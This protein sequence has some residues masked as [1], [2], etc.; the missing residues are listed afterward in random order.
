LY[1]AV[2]EQFARLR[3][4]GVTYRVIPGVTAAFAASAALG[5]EYTLPEVCQTLIITRAAGRTPTPELEDLAFLARHRAAMAIYLSA[6]LADQVAGALAPHYGRDAAAAVVYRASWPDE[7]ILFTTVGDLARDMAEAGVDRQAL[8][9]VGEAV[10][11][12]QKGEK[13]PASRLY[14]SSFSHGYRRGPAK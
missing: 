13:S 5:L 8:I 12:L 2:Q 3:E 7:K 4:A 9:L 14:S 6:G 1:G 11:R 10:T